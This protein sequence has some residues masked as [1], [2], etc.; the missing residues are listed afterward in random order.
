MM[1]GALQRSIFVLE[2]KR[3][4]LLANTFCRVGDNHIAS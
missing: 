1:L 2:K 3:A 4:R